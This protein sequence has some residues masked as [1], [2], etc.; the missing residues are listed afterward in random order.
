MLLER[1]RGRV[2]RFRCSAATDPVDPLFDQRSHIDLDYTLKVSGRVGSEAREF[3]VG[4]GQGAHIK[5]QFGLGAQCPV[6][7]CQLRIHGWRRGIA[8][9]CGNREKAM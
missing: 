9:R 5:H 7:R 1:L 3:L 6:M 2:C 8:E 4:V